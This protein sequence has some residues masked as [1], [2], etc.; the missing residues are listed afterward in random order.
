[1]PLYKLRE[2]K[3]GYNQ[4]ELIARHICKREGFKLEAGA[5]RRI[6]DT[7]SQTHKQRD[8]RL[9]NVFAAFTVAKPDAIKDQTILLIDDVITTGATLGECALML[10]Y[11]GAKRIYALTYCAAI[12]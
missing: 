11:Y 9:K 7:A 2:R 8:E 4:S 6:K 10:R 1:V 12:D 3:R 5:L